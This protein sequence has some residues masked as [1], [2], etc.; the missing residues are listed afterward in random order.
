MSN[1]EFC[2]TVSFQGR[3]E[4]VLPQQCSKHTV[5]KSNAAILLKWP[6]MQ[7]IR[8]HKKWMRRADKLTYLF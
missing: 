4:I 8:V 6:K 1:A 3:E 5:S 2:K 7:H